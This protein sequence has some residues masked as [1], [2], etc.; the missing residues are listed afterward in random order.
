MSRRKGKKYPYVRKN[1]VKGRIYWRFEKGDFRT[2][3]PGPFGSSDFDSAYEAALE[4]VKLPKVRAKTD[5]IGW[6]IEQFLSSDRYKY[7]SP[8]RKETLRYQFDWLREQAG[9]LP[10]ARMEVEH[11]EALMA[12]KEGPSAANTVKKNLSMLYN[13]AAKKK[14]YKG[15]NP[16]KLADRLK[17]SRGGYH[18][19]TDA[20]VAR[21]LTRHGPGTKARLAILIAL[22]TGMARQDLCGANRDMLRVK[23]GKL[24][25]EYARGKT[26]VAADLPVIPELA[27]ELERLPPEQ[28]I[29]LAKDDL[30]EAYK[31]TSF[32]NWF[33]DRCREAEVP[34]SIHGLRKAGATRLADAG[35]SDWEIAS[36]L[37]HT[38]T[39]QASVYTRRANRSK[40]AD[41]GF[42]KLGKLSNSS[43]PLDSE[44]E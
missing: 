44:K 30:R 32:G 20:E 7:S 23:N 3:I 14:R 26:G 29:F 34:G 11:V 4:H 42:K 28:H 41:S 9:D 36:Y 40:L 31:V 18:T 21:F 27:E 33:R 22:N 1:I 43:D 16:A 15:H 17:E 25:I 19:W 13:F 10:F 37:A 39:T 6:L 12:K 24:R 35:A 38:D 2:N 8:I 5:T